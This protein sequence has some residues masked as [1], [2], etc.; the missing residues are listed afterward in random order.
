MCRIS[1]KI[2]GGKGQWATYM[3]MLRK[4]AGHVLVGLHKFII[5]FYLL[6]SIFEFSTQ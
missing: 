4:Q 5:L 3:R 1:L 2:T 6:L